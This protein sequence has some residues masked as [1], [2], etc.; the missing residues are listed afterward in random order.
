M[1]PLLCQGGYGMPIKAGKFEIIQIEA[2]GSDTNASSRLTLLDDTEVEP[3]DDKWGQLVKTKTKVHHIIYDQKRVAA[4][5][6]NLST[7]LKEPIKVRNG[8]SVL[9]ATNLVPGSI[10]V[11][12]K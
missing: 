5:H 9:N 6:A 10:M 3:T 7:E 1:Y 4:C 12:A 11:Y 8:L 2:P